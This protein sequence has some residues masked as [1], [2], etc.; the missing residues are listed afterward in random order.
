MADRKFAVEVHPAGI[1]VTI[2]PVVVYG[3]GITAEKPSVF[4]LELAPAHQPGRLLHLGMN[5]ADAIHLRNCLIAGL[6]Q[7]Q[8]T[9]SNS[10]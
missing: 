1:P 9:R 2:L 10:N 3:I 4:T 6:E 7:E 5:E 8:A